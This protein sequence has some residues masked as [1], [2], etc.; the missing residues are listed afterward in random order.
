[1]CSSNG[2]AARRFV[3]PCRRNFLTGNSVGT[4]CRSVKPEAAGS[5]P[6][7]SANL[8]QL[9]ANDCYMKVKKFMKRTRN[10]VGVTTGSLICRLSFPETDEQYDLRPLGDSKSALENIRKFVKHHLDE[11]SS[12]L[13]GAK[14]TISAEIRAQSGGL[15]R[16]T[17]AIWQAGRW[18]S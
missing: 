1:M 7:L 17:L 6:A 8:L 2:R 14:L 9:N 4:E 12:Q 13:E 11:R 3:I 16:H 15:R 5:N 18:L 10:K